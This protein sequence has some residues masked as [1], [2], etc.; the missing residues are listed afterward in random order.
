MDSLEQRVT[1]V[2]ARITFLERSLNNGFDLSLSRASKIIGISREGIRKR[3][4][5]AISCPSLSP[6]KEG[7]HFERRGCKKVILDAVEARKAIANH[8]LI[9]RK[10]NRNKEKTN[11]H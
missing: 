4:N 9:F 2:E 6:L 1:N 8:D 10:R 11:D 7:V 5:E 3:I